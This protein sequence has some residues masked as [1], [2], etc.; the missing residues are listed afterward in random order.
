MNSAGSFSADGDLP[1]VRE[2]RLPGPKLMR[3]MC[4]SPPEHFL[5]IEVPGLQVETP[6]GLW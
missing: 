1:A 6:P 5:G 3:P 2:D 4:F